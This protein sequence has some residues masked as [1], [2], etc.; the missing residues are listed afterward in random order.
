MNGGFQIKKMC[1]GLVG[2]VS[3]KK[4]FK[5]TTFNFFPRSIQY[6]YEPLAAVHHSADRLSFG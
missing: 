6:N 1:G 2:V 3:R 4:D 5:L